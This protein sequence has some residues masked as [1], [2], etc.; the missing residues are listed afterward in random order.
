[1]GC[2]KTTELIALV[3]AAIV[4]FFVLRVLVAR[5]TGYR[6]VAREVPPTF[7]ERA[8]SVS[9]TAP[10]RALPVAAAALLLYVGL[11]ALDLLYAPWGRVAAAVLKAILVFAAVTTVISMVLTPSEPNWR[12]VQ[13]SDR[14]AGRIVWLLYAITGVYAVDVALTEIS[15][16]FFVPLPVSVVQSFVASTLFATLLIG[17]LLTPFEPR[18]RHS[19]RWLKAPLWLIAFSILAAD[20]A[21][22]CRARTLHRSAAGHDQHRRRY[23]LPRLTGDPRRHAR[24][25]VHDLSGRRDARSPL[26]AGCAAPPPARAPDRAAL[27]LALSSVRCRC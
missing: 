22:L 18:P 6:H 2:H 5:Y 11:D 24:A 20:P 10:L 3:L 1:L 21:R 19:P 25:A 7:F 9:W 8:F 4:G 12:F 16:V 14:A 15:R 27:T 23:R 17:L 26:R 13:L